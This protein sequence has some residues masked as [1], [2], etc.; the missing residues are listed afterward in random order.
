MSEVK[1]SHF[2][3]STLLVYSELRENSAEIQDLWMNATLT[4]YII[5]NGHEEL[6]NTRFRYVEAFTNERGVIT[7]E[8]VTW[9]V[10]VRPV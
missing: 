7:S 9:V 4:Q 2:K 5:D 1:E 8:V 3:S 10:R 6:A